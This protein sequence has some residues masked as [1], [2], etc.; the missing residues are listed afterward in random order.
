MRAKDVEKHRREEARLQ[1]R[2]DSLTRFVE[3]RLSPLLCIGSSLLYIPWQVSYITVCET[4]L[5]TR[6]IADCC[7]KLE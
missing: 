1:D 7:P 4:H 5:D 3:V 6:M 2:Y